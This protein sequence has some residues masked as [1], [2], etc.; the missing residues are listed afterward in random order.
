MLEVFDCLTDG[1]IAIRPLV[2]YDGKGSMGDSPMYGCGIYLC[3]TGGRVGEISVRVASTESVIK[4]DGHIGFGIDE[5]H[6]GNGYAGRACHLARQLLVRHG[7]H[8]A[9]LTCNPDNTASR[10]TCTRIGALLSEVVDVPVGHPQYAD[11][12]PRLSRYVWRI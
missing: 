11:G 6:R 9:V 5:E 1:V 8:E 12:N 10:K 4:Y 3:R 2:Y 7:I